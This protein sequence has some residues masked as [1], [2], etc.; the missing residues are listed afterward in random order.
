MNRASTSFFHPRIRPVKPDGKH[1]N[2][3]ISICTNKDGHVLDGLQFWMIV[4]NDRLKWST[5][6]LNDRL[7][8]GL[9][10][11]HNSGFNS[12][13]W[14][15]YFIDYR[16]VKEITIF[17]K[18]NSTIRVTWLYKFE[19]SVSKP[20]TE[21]YLQ[22]H[23]SRSHRWTNNNQDCKSDFDFLKYTLRQYAN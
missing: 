16:I 21:R 6:I 17:C 9:K 20:V 3:V 22:S 5:S 1:Q 14:L 4:L 11:M 18:V 2:T 7:L 15:F 23:H 10:E 8:W 12:P 13:R 19:A